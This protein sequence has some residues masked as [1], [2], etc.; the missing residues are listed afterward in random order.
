MANGI[1]LNIEC[2]KVPK[3]PKI[4]DINILGMA[5]LKGFLDFSM[6]TPKDCTLSINLMLQLA[7]LLA[8]MTCLLKMLAVLQAMKDGLTSDPPDFLA[9]LPK[10]GEL[11]ECFAAISWPTIAITI[12]AVLELVINFLSCFIDQLKSLLTF[13]ASI[14]LSSAEG[15]PVLRASLECARENAQNSIDNLMLSLEPI[16]PLF[17]MSKSLAGVVGMELELPDVTEL[18]KA[19][20]KVEVIGDIE[21]VTGKLKKTIESL[22]A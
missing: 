16:K 1:D 2:P 15:N 22:P 8:S 11:V 4:P 10:L 13:Q 12:K 21:K 19:S 17:D 7:P 5:N 9:P 3:I 18:S 14:D 20:G 6:G